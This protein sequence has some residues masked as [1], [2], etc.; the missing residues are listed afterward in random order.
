MQLIKDWTSSFMWNCCS[1]SQWPRFI[2][3]SE[4]PLSQSAVIVEQRGVLTSFNWLKLLSLSHNV[5]GRVGAGC[6]STLMLGNIYQ[7]FWE[8]LTECAASIS[9][10]TS[11]I[12]WEPLLHVIDWTHKRWLDFVALCLQG[13]VTPWLRVLHYFSYCQPSAAVC[14]SAVICERNSL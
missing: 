4:R 12:Q 9:S 10:P 7:L 8:D 13:F 6:S 2:F 5:M 11:G 1:F 3:I 14:S